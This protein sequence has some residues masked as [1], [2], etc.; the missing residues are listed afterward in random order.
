MPQCGQP[1]IKIWILALPCKS[2]LSVVENFFKL[3][4]LTF[5]CKPIQNPFS[6][7]MQLLNRHFTSSPVGLFV[8]CSAAI[9]RIAIFFLIG[10]LLNSFLLRCGMKMRPQLH[11]HILLFISWRRFNHIT[12]CGLNRGIGESKMGRSSSHIEVFSLTDKLHSNSRI[13]L[14]T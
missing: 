13:V 4:R 7:I 5:N 9:F 12:R 3:K 8:V 10:R 1:G 11:V 14:L 2:T 6:K